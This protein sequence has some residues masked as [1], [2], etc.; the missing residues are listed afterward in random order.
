MFPIYI[1]FKLFTVYNLYKKIKSFAVIQHTYI[2][3]CPKDPEQPGKDHKGQSLEK[4]KTC[5]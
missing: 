3:E 2:H 1:H 4:E 5:V